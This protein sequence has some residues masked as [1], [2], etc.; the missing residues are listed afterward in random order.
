MLIQVEGMLN[1]CP[2]TYQ[3]E[4]LDLEVITPNQLIF[5]DNSVRRRYWQ[6]GKIVKQ[7]KSED[8]VTWAVMVQIAS[9]G[10]VYEIERP[11]QG[12]CP[13]EIDAPINK[14]KNNAALNQHSA[15]LSELA[16]QQSA[17]S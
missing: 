7:L 6:M 5:V 4:E 17:T 8:S 9:Q 16:E 13:F 15:V 3:T 11:L 2:L 1:N 12:I 14:K 10:K